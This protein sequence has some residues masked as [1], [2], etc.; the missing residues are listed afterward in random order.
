MALQGNQS[1]IFLNGVDLSCVT[2]QLTVENTTDEFD[3][4]TLCSTVMEYRPGSGR[5]SIGIEGYFDGV[6]TGQAENALYTALAASDKIVAAMLDFSAV[7]APAYILENASNL[8]MTWASPADSLL[9]MNGKFQASLGLKRGS[10]LIYKSAR[11]STGI[12]A[13]AE[14]T[15]VTTSSTGR[16]YVFLTDF[17]G[18]IGSNVAVSLQTSANGTSGWATEQTFSFA[19]KGALAA[20][21]TTPAGRYFA[22]NVTGLG[23]ATSATLSLIVVIDGLTS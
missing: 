6:E 18:T 4:S 15:G 1:R 8:G 13:V 20:P 12:G 11:T 19:A 17:A 5:G 3:A 21:L 2:S 14:L 23:G 7:P 9:T 16:L 10:L 22:L